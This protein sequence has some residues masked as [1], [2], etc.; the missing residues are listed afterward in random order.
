MTD[1]YALR[2]RIY[3][4]VLLILPCFLLGTLYSISLK[5]FIPIITSA[6]VVGALLYLLS[7]LGRTLGKKKENKLWL[8]WGGMPTTLILRWSDS[9]F[10]LHTKGRYHK[11]LQQLAPVINPPDSAVEGDDLQYADSV[12]QSWSGYLRNQTRDK[13]K[14][15]LL[16]KENVGYGFR[17]NLWGLKSLAIFLLVLLSAFNYL[18]NVYQLKNWRLEVMPQNFYYGCAMIL[19]FFLFWIF[20]VT[21][22]WVK[23]A[24]FAYA[25]RL[26]ESA[27]S[28]QQ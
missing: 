20:V 14:Y 27:D 17:R 9:T 1:G 24:A 13:E 4:M 6:V 21:K 25:R 22:S 16:F 28:L 3:P 8:N 5:S 26:I 15:N 12:Y 11:K 2:A 23:S 19:F 18:Y 7:H 10:D